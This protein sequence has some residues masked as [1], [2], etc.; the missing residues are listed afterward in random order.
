MNIEKYPL[1]PTAMGDATIEVIPFRIRTDDLMT[2]EGMGTG[3]AVVLFLVCLD[4]QRVFFVCLTDLIE[5]VTTP[6]DPNWR[7]KESKILMVPLR[8]EVALTHASHVQLRFYSARTKLLGLFNKL[9]YQSVELTYASEDYEEVLRLGAHFREVLL[10]LEVWDLP[11]WAGLQLYKNELVRLP[12]G[13][14]NLPSEAATRVIL[15]LWKRMSVLGRT[16]EEMCREW[17]LPTYLAHLSSY[18]PGR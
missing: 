2:F 18:P 3:T 6:E 13:T 16:Y 17:L 12:D 10:R 9:H 15:G 14:H 8:N 5:K 7:N 11:S 4:S 1:T